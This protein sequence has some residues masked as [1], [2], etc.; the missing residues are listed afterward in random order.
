LD[1]HFKIWPFNTDNLALAIAEANPLITY[2]QVLDK[3]H[4]KYLCQYLDDGTK[5]HG[6]GVKSIILENKYIDR[7]Y[8]ADFTTYYAL[9]FSGG[10]E[11]YCRRLHFF[12]H[13]I[14]KETFFSIIAQPNSIDNKKIWEEYVGSCI[15]KPLPNCFLGRTILKTYDNT[16]IRN[17]KFPATRTYVQNVFGIKL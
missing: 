2:Q 12:S 17:R 15:I 3:R 7:D 16:N 9:C 4:Y 1:D 10:Y 13:E 5:Q 11:R 6:M 14:D 8:L